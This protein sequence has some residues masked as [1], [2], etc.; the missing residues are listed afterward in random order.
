[1]SVSVTGGSASAPNQSMPAH[2]ATMRAALLRRFVSAYWLRP[3]NALWMA[4]R[5]EALGECQWTP[6]SVDVSCGDGI[7]TF[8]TLG[9]EL[10]PEFDVFQ[11][12]KSVRGGD[13]A[14][15]FDH[16]SDDYVPRVITSPSTVIDIGSDLKPALLAK[17]A[18]LGVYDATRQV[19]NE[20]RLPFDDS[21]F[22]TIYCNAAYWVRGIDAFLGELR[23]ICA[24]DGR[25]ILHVKL[26]SLFD[27][28]LR[29]YRDR[30]GQ[31]FLDII[32][33]G[34]ADSWPTVADEDEW[35]RRFADA[36]FEIAAKRPFVTA[37]HAHI[38]D[39][40]LR[41]VAPMLVRMTDAIAPD[42]R[43]SIKR[44][45]TDVMCE[46]LLPFFD[47]AL[48]LSAAARPPVEIQYELR[49]S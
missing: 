38:W 39:I 34:R 15:M 11:S 2:P 32:D 1:M 27:C 30:L 13:S 42:T 36:G 14:D 18:V 47:P 17:A 4:L 5:A 29:G 25:V 24:N 9:G 33:R 48:D 10:D 28:T 46:L 26:R 6:P 21:S 31:R 40:G 19:D 44:E 7:F 23:R 43:A 35:E 8:L 45:W 3:E 20:A 41:P 16:V 49:P 12:V 22:Q 37:T